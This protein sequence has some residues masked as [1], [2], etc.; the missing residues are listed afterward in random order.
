MTF[1]VLIDHTIQSDSRGAKSAVGSNSE[2]VQSFMTQK[3]NEISQWKN[4]VE[5]LEKEN[6]KLRVESV[7]IKEH[8]SRQL[9]GNALTGEDP[10]DKQL[11]KDI[12][13]NPQLL[14]YI[15]SFKA[16]IKHL[17]TINRQHDQNSK[18]YEEMNAQQ[19]ELEKSQ[20]KTAK[21]DFKCYL[22]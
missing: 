22:G 11:M 16:K 20:V 4:R 9:G 19:K 15:G 18:I 5:A 6:D 10:S 13:G 21:N 14:A 8:L 17:E 7:K 12:S 3:N 2:H 1:L